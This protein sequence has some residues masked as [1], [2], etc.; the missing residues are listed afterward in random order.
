MRTLLPLSPLAMIA[1]V[2]VAAAPLDEMHQEGE[3]KLQEA[4]HSQ[5]KIDDIVKG[6]QERLI[7]YRSLMK[8]IDGL[9]TYNT[10]LATQT[11]NQ[12]NLLAR[13][14][15]SIAQ[16]SL[17]ERQMSPLIMRMTD[18]LQEFVE[19]DLPFHFEERRERLAFLREN[20]LAADIDLAEKF[21]QIIEAYQ[22]E[23]E[24]GRKIDSY[25][26]IVRIDGSDH[27]VDVLRVGRIALLCQTRD[28]KITALWD[29]A[30]ARWRLL[31]NATYRNPTRYA[32]KMARKQ[33]PIDMVV[34]P[35]NAPQ[36][37]APEATQ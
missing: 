36:A 28:S 21:R 22:I 27:E 14:E 25:Q 12:D 17:I 19:L 3:K 32:I 8:Q 13:L 11:A 6:T 2:A 9:E 16:V 20:Q 34:L 30:A 24:Y 29:H 26:D 7:L 23:N 15:T 10:Q 35:I 18:S 5:E 1:C 31:D 37:A 33:V 4:K